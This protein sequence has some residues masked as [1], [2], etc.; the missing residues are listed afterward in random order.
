MNNQKPFEKS[1]PTLSQS[2]LSGSL[3]G[4]TEALVNHP[5]WTIKTRLQNREPLLYHPN[6]LYRGLILSVLSKVPITA[7][8]VGLNRAIQTFIYNDP[9]ELSTSQTMSCAFFAGVGSALICCP[10]EMIVTDKR[11]DNA[12][13]YKATQ[14][15]YSRGGIAKLC[16]G[17]LATALREGLFT[18]FFIAI[19]PFFKTTIQPYGL[20][21]TSASII[22]GILAGLGATVSSQA[23]DTIKTVQQCSNIIIGFTPCAKKIYQTQGI[24]GFFN[25]M[26]PRGARV[27]SAVT[28]L[29]FL[30]EKADDLVSQPRL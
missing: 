27:V 14:R 11:I 4:A 26:L 19:T 1:R 6:I 13:V 21:N 24:P 12:S 5:L 25:G 28:L 15:L 18:V 30:K 20:N 10:T 9:L 2:I 23:F 3:L 7:S 22:A 29:G 16:T 17:L 8:Q